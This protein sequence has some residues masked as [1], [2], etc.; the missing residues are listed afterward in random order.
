[1]AEINVHVNSTEPVDTEPQENE[2][3]TNTTPTPTRPEVEQEKTV[4][5]NQRLKS[6]TRLLIKAE[7]LKQTYKH[8]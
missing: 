3:D 2:P 7:R 1:M 5:K 8:K 4:E 6:H